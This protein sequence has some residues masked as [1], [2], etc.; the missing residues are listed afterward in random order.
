LNV[1]I[2]EDSRALQKRLTEMLSKVSGLNLVG[3]A[4]CVAEARQ[5]IEKLHPDLVILDLQLADGNGIEVLCETK[6]NYPLIRFVVFTNQSELQYRQR[7]LD[8]GADYF[9]CKS[10][11]AK[12]LLAISEVLVAD[13]GYNSDEPS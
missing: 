8:L 1:L 6:T 2:V 4:K 10:T 9:L 11:G 7:C 13:E 12:S 5:V 3:Q